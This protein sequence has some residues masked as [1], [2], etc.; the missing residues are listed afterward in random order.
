MLDV[1]RLRVLAAVARHGSFA[2]AASEL[3]YTPA[4]V[5]QQ[6]AALE[7]ESGIRA[8]RR[9]ARGARLTDAGQ[10]LLRHAEQ[11]FAQ[12]AAAE[13][14]LEA[15]RDA[16]HRE[17]RV[18]A[19]PAAWK[20]LVPRAVEVVRNRHP[21]VE[22]RLRSAEPEESIPALNHAELD[23]ALVYEPNCGP[24]LDE[25]LERVHVSEHPLY[26]ALPRAHT[27][28]EQPEVTLADLATTPWVDAEDLL[29]RPACQA[30]GFEPEVAFTSDD[31]TAVQ[32][33]VATGE[34]AALV[35]LNSVVPR[36]DVV[37]RPLSEPPT[38]RVIAVSSPFRAAAAKAFID[39]V[40]EVARV[41]EG[42]RHLRVVAR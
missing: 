3:G 1:R 39:A 34:A 38:R 10:V 25:S 8:F 37:V 26:V 32:G 36:D 31:Y 11:I 17:V 24:P 29:L 14:E 27:L 30:S 7:R 42:E 28:A 15:H 22:L 5:S 21:D 9:H 41:E 23:V 6:I 13:S 18:A 2:G 33:F 40:R 12:I 4:A 20:A 16:R 35:P 19:F